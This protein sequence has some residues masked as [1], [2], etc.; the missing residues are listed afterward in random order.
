[1]NPETYFIVTFR[2]QEKSGSEKAMSVKVK[3]VTDSNLGLSFIRLSDFI[4]S[5]HSIVL[6][7][8]QEA[9]K[10]R[11]EKT[12]SLHLSLYQIISIEEVGSEHQGLTFDQDKNNLLTLPPRHEH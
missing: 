1:M 6:D 10:A 8:T 9:L 7:P 5:G 3:T 4:F 11:F 2:D 12:K